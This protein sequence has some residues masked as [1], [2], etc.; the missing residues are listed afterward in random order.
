MTRMAAFR[1]LRRLFV[2]SLVVVTLF[3]FGFYG[4]VNQ[5]I[6]LSSPEADFRIT[7]GS[8]VRGAIKSINEAGISL[9]PQMAMLLVKV[10][11]AESR[12]KAGTYT[13][14]NGQTHYELIMKVKN[15]DVSLVELRFPEGWTFK[16]WRQYLAQQTGIDHQIGPLS[17]AEVLKKLNIPFSHPEGLFFPDTYRVDK[18]ASDL[19]FLARAFKLSQEKLQAAWQNRNEGLPYRNPYEALIMASIVEKETGKP[20]DRQKVAAVFVNRLKTGMRL[21][22]DPTVIYGLGERFDGNLRKADLLTDTPYNSY[23][24]AG[25]PPTPIAMPGMAAIH[26]ALNPEKIDYFYFV[27]R[28]DGTSQFS[29]TLDEHNAAV[30]QYQLK[31]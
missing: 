15:G 18:H 2:L 3:G 23:T 29:R 5:A 9:Q 22:T 10:L 17:D 28:G 19:E 4:W 30:R 25:L 20:E 8:S 27:A 6:E 21:Q 7:P 1:L 13:I 26:A 12:L 31:R 14:K 16:Q 11:G 24:R